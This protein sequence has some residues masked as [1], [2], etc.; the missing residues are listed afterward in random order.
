MRSEASSYSNAYDKHLSYRSAL[1]DVGPRF[2]VRTRYML[3]YL[4][5]S[6]GRTIDIGCGDGFSLAVYQS[7]GLQADGIDASREAIEQCKRR[8][9]EDY[10]GEIECCYIDEF[11]PRDPYDLLLC[12][13][14]L[15]H[16]E[17]D[18]GFLGHMNRIARP[19][20][21]LVLTVPIDMSLW[22][23]AD[24]NA[25]HFRRYSREEI[26]EKL[27]RNGF[28][29]EDYLVWGWPLTRCLMPHI[30][31]RQD[32]MTGAAGG[33]DARAERA[34]MKRFRFALKYVKYL[35]LL[36]GLFNFTERGVGIIIKARK[37]REA[38]LGRPR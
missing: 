26:F 18:E 20:A 38:T 35:F 16:I 36:D 5:R 14:V 25:G 4:P 13:E 34:F 1:L 33:S 27:E 37:A 3:S 2:Y 31:K 29:V 32:K 6:P 21:T 7:K 24:A 30:R 12:G 9:G 10:P 19:N 22:S 28:Q 17:D 8:L 15:E 23:E 11:H